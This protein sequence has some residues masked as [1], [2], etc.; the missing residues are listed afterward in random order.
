MP[1]KIRRLLYKAPAQ[2]DLI[3]L[4]QSGKN[5]HIERIR[6]RCLALQ[7]DAESQFDVNLLETNPPLFNCFVFGAELEGLIPDNQGYEV[8][9]SMNKK[10]VAILR[11]LP[12]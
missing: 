5:Q 10:T 12:Y 9:F 1:K 4:K 6:A 11:I 2:Q 3:Q 8:F 7:A